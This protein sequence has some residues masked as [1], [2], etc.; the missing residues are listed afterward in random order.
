M[1][2]PTNVIGQHKFKNLSTD[3]TTSM[4]KLPILSIGNCPMKRVN[5]EA[6]VN[7]TYSGV[8]NEIINSKHYPLEQEED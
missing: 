1:P 7:R 4:E 6:L 3:M 8:S 2:N 5:W